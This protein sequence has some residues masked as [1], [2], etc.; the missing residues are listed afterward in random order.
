MRRGICLSLI[1]MLLCSVGT[2][3]QS[4]R[5]TITGT[6]ADASG[7]VLPGVGI[8][9]VNSETG[10]RYETVATET[11]NYALNQLPAGEYEIT[12]EL[13][14]FRKYVRRGITVLVGQTLRIDVGLAVGS[15]TEEISV[16]ADA[17]LLK[18]ESGELSHNIATAQLN[19]LP[20]LPIGGGGSAGIRNPLSATRLAPGTNFSSNLVLRVNGAPT[21]TQAIRIEGQDATNGYVPLPEGG[22]IGSWPTGVLDETQRTDA[23]QDHTLGFRYRQPLASLPI[24]FSLRRETAFEG[25]KPPRISLQPDAAS[26]ECP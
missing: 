13:P 17:P 3:A 15:P 21:N 22:K 14:G 18:T 6:V 8:V 26:D 16:T 7:A 12:A 19:E 2:F 4:D 10:A 23:T 9:A 25:Q 5:G 20:I 11:G 24:S 1:M